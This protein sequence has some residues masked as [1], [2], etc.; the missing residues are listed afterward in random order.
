MSKNG[1]FYIPTDIEWDIPIFFETFYRISYVKKTIQN[2]FMDIPVD[3]PTL[4]YM[5][6]VCRFR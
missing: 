4:N 2:I 1:V 6:V 3:I 5:C